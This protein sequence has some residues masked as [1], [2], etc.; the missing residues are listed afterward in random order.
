MSNKKRQS[1]RKPKFPSK[2]NDHVMNSMSQNK[3]DLNGIDEIKVTIDDKSVENEENCNVMNRNVI[4]GVVEDVC[5]SDSDNE[6]DLESGGQKIGEL[7]KEENK[8]VF[9]WVDKDLKECNVVFG[10]IDTIKFDQSGNY[11]LDYVETVVNVENMMDEVIVESVMKNSSNETGSGT[12]E[13]DASNNGDTARRNDAVN[14]KGD[15]EK[16]VDEVQEVFKGTDVYE[17]TCTNDKS[18]NTFESDGKLLEIPAE[19]DDD[20]V[21]VV[22]FDEIMVEEGRMGRVGYARVLVEASTKKPLP[23]DIDVVHKNGSKEC[24]KSRNG[25]RKEDRG[26][27]V[28]MEEKNESGPKQNRNNEKIDTEGF[29]TIQHKR[30][31]SMNEKVLRPNFKPNTQIPRYQARKPNKHYE[32]Q[33]K[34]KANN[35]SANVRTTTQQENARNVDKAAN[36]QTTPNKQTDKN[37]SANKY[38]ILESYDETEVVELQEI[39][40]KEVVERFIQQKKILNEN[41]TRRWNQ[42]MINYYK[43]RIFSLHKGEAVKEVDDVFKYVTGMVQCMKSDG[44]NGLDG[45]V[46]YEC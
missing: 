37:D 10:S 21:E 43:E 23:Y 15:V 29:T 4:E 2:F 33:P 5:D 22:V 6:F 13:G 41:E 18:D 44:M 34:K 14:D 42:T 30:R 1:K 16:G 45:N 36:Q 32:F 26:K 40:D 39:K 31:F 25:I 19:I 8:G 28:D 46:L 20:G 3:K 35:A 12:K 27:N 7:R 38:S 24:V 9:G 17:Q 11:G